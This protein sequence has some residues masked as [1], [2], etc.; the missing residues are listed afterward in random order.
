MINPLS[1]P[2]NKNLTPVKLSCDFILQQEQFVDTDALNTL[3]VEAAY[4]VAL[5]EDAVILLGSKAQDIIT[6]LGVNAHNLADKPMAV[7]C[8]NELMR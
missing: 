5:A 3:V 2:I 4:P 6:G 8:P 7:V 1:I